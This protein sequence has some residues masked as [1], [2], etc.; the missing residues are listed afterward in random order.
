[1]ALDRFITLSE[2]AQRMRTSVKETRSM[3]KSGK[4]KGGLL[5]DGAMVVSEDTIPKRKEKS[6]EDLLE[7]KR[8]KKLN[9]VGVWISE[10]SRKYNIPTTT[11]YQW[12][13][14]GYIKNIGRDGQKVL[15]NEQDVA[16]CAGVYE[17]HKG[18]GKWI[19]NSD[20]TPYIPNNGSS[21]KKKD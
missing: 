4:I 6:K 10:A 12:F 15:L 17:K 19:F 14:K 20:G 16:Y 3:I 5:P 18:K 8:Y 1:M 7:Y 9:G 13:Q 21:A 11:L 2:A